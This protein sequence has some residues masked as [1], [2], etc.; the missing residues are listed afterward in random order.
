MHRKNSFKQN[1]QS[2]IDYTDDVI[3]CSVKK[4]C[5]DKLNR[6]EDV[7]QDCSDRGERLNSAA[8]TEG[9]VA[10]GQGKAVS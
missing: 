9:F 5:T 4:N 10:N 2:K 3:M 7:T 1:L 8:T 6:Q